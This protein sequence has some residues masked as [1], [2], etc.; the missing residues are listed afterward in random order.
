MKISNEMKIGFWTIVT[1]IILVAGI[2]YLKG[3]NLLSRGT[4]YYVKASNVEGLAVSSHV[5]YN[6]LKV[7]M[8]REMDYQKGDIILN[9]NIEGDIEV[10][11]DSHAEIRTDLL[12]TSSII[13]HLGQSSNLLADG[14]T[15]QG[16]ERELGLIDEVKPMLP[17][18]N[19]MLPKVDSILSG[20]NMLI[21]G[22]ELKES[23]SNIHTLTERLTETTQQLN[24]LMKNE[25]PS[26]L[27]H[28]HNIVEN[29]D[30]ITSQVRRAQ[31]EETLTAA[32]AALDSVNRVLAQIS[33]EES[34]TGKLLTT[35]ELH[36][37]LIQTIGEVDSL[38]ADIRQNPS[39]YINISVFGGKDKNKEAK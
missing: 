39:R 38:I 2:Q 5:L 15:I 22:I 8:V 37:R 7:G 28:S 36:D 9:I 16:G 4:F 3:I 34:T 20:L 1:I 19:T 27:K 31:V 24:S 12:G 11:S 35:T 33:N 18:L 17:S 25:L 6:G 23:M 14:D 13:L 29:L 30:T 32:H 10:P 26:M 21:N